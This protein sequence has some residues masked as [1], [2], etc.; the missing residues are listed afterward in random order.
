M[1]SLWY[2]SGLCFWVYQG[3]FWHCIRHDKCRLS[4]QPFAIY[5][6]CF[7]HCIKHDK[8]HWSWQ[9]FDIYRGYVSGEVRLPSSGSEAKLLKTFIVRNSLDKL[10]HFQVCIIPKATALTSSI[11]SAIALNKGGTCCLALFNN[12]T[13]PGASH[14]FLSVTNINEQHFTPW[15]FESWNRNNKHQA[16]A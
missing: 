13:I 6:G 11:L 5:Q 1:T 16:L 7:W 15:S 14:S 10:E 3:C 8:F 12:L 4:W 9:D 2:L